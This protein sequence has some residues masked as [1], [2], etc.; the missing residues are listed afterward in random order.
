MREARQSKKDAIFRRL[1]SY[2]RQAPYFSI[3]KV[4]ADAE[5]DN[6]KLSPELLREYLSEAMQRK[7]IHDAGRG[8]YSALPDAAVLDPAPVEA[9]RA[10]L[11]GRFPFLPHYVWSTRQFNPWMHHLVGKP[12]S[13]VQVER[14]GVHD[15]AAFLRQE[16]W[17]VLVNPTSKTAGEFV[18]GERSVVIRGIQRTFDPQAEP[19][20]ETALVDLL[21]ENSR[22]GLMD[23]EERREMSHKLLVSNRVAMASLL[24]RLGDHKRS[25]EDLVGDTEQPIMAEK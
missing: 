20:I 19:R 1:R 18:P 10:T 2:G 7:L 16:G 24:A 6:L 8:W 12:V 14:E 5:L 25:L 13:F 4:R 23:E 22:L 9:L 11:A 3:E 15:V 21:L 17:T